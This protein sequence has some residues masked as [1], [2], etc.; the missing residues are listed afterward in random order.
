MPA[1][2]LTATAVRAAKKPGRY[3]DGAGL[4]LY[5]RSEDA[6]FWV[7]RK[8]VRGQSYEIGIGP[9]RDVSLAQAREKAADLRRRLKAGESIEA[10]RAA[11]GDGGK[12]MTFAEAAEKV[13]AERLPGWKNPKHAA[14][15]INTLEA[16]AFPTM[17]RLPV[18]DVTSGHILTAVQPLWLEKPETA[19]RVKQRIF[20]VLDWAAG[21][22]HREDMAPARAVDA[23]LKKQKKVERHFAAMPYPEVPALMAK[24]EQSSGV[25]ALSLRFAILTAA[26]SGEVRGATWGEIDL[27]AKTWIIPAS[28]MKAGEEHTVPLSQAALNVLENARLLTNGAAETVVFP[29][30]R[31]KP[32]SGMTLAKALKT[33]GAGQFTVHGM[34]SSFRDWAAETTDFA[35]D[36]VEAALAHKQRNKVEAA[37][38]RTNYLEKRRELMDLWGVFCVR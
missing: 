5:V 25:G 4:H 21:H 7:L 16:Y 28:R 31:Q 38:R 34:R 35:G 8:Q 33:A 23:A 14:Q 11:D 2:K 19:R 15:W 26:R 27:Q 29:G 30:M 1:N 9:L 22:K 12:R 17:G 32:M 3:F 10:I 18:G 20:S 37:Y 13:H 24:L 6:R 36:V